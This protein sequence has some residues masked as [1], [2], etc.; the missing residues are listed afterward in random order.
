M[1][2]IGSFWICN[3]VLATTLC[4]LLIFFIISIYLLKVS[5]QKGLGS[6]GALV[7]IPHFFFFFT[8]NG[9]ISSRYSSVEVQEHP[10]FFK[11]VFN[12]VYFLIG[13]QIIT[14]PS[15]YKFLNIYYNYFIKLIQG[16]LYSG[17]EIWGVVLI[18]KSKT[19]L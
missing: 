1:T 4:K 7:W 2:C 10:L 12:L 6:Q 16:F 9:C 17:W 5:Q 14:S 18:L 11:K 3:K 19:T 8:F 13:T 15:C